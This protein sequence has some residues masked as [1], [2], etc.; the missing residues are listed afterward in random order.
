MIASGNVVT[1]R[2]KRRCI[3][4]LFQKPGPALDTLSHA[5]WI[6]RKGWGFLKKL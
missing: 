5:E 2:T 4:E 3:R 6:D 1:M